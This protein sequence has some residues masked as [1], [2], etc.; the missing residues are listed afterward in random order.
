M[1]PPPPR[2][3][4]RLPPVPARPLPGDISSLRASFIAPLL[5]KWVNGTR[6]HY[7][8]LEDPPT[9]LGNAEANLD[10]V[11]RA[12]R[13][14]QGLGIGLDFIE[15]GDAA[16]AE[17]RIA[18]RNDGSWSYVGRQAL[19]ITDP[20]E[21]TM[22]FGWDLT[23]EYGYDTALHEIGH[24]IGLGHEHQNPRAGIV[25]N[26]E[27]VHRYF[28]APPNEFT[29]E[30]IRRNILDKQSLAGTYGSSWDRDSIMHYH[31][32]AGLIL[33]P[34]EYREKPLIPAP[35]LSQ[36][37]IQ[38]A[39]RFYPPL[40][41]TALPLLRPFTSMPI[42][43]AP[44]GQVDLEIR[45]ELSRDYS[46]STFGQLDTVM[47]LFELVDGAPCYVK[48]D[49]DSGTDGNAR[50][51]HRLVRGREYRLRIRLHYAGSLGHG[52]VMMW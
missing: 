4:C 27:A 50:I 11:R 34:S 25:W 39:R 8:F 42:D 49:D 5:T 41:A 30:E 10:A 24:A 47:V 7:C 44:G 14:W 48:G 51:V 28:S 20:R 36:L 26:V 9:W 40:S 1:A 35:G 6:L 21:P 29:P 12:F 37:D 38:H 13:E 46:I 19:Q 43:V 17:I 16:E 52:A 3:T 32:D 45:P 31:F 2:S 33:E 23:D 22:N 18:F 15:V